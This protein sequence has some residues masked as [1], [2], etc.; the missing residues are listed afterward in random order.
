MRFRLKQFDPTDSQL[1]GF[2]EEA[3]AFRNGSVERL[4]DMQ[5]KLY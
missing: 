4:G 1:F 3:D 5:Q 2:D